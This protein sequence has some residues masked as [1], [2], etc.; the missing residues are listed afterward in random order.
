MTVSFETLW[1]DIETLL[2]IAGEGWSTAELVTVTYGCKGL[3]T[4]SGVPALRGSVQREL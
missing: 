2:E 3:Y 4:E 1:D